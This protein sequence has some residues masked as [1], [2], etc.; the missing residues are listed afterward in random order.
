MYVCILKI[1]VDNQE[2]VLIYFENP[3][4]QPGA[5]TYIF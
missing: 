3:C 1:R 5:C 4:R 2:H